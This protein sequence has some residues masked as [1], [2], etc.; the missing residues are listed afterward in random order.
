MASF[1]SDSLVS[2]M[3][4]FNIKPMGALEPSKSKV[5]LNLID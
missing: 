4:C 1:T 3:C 5:H 2:L